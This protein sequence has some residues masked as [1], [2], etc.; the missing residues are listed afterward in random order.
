MNDELKGKIKKLTD[1]IN[2][3]LV[4]GSLGLA[5]LGYINLVED[6]SVGGYLKD[7]Q[8]SQKRVQNELDK[9][10]EMRFYKKLFYL[11]SKRAFEDYLEEKKKK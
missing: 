11:G 4:Y 8:V 1:I 6:I 3:I 10:E 7:N 2:P 5:A 9:I